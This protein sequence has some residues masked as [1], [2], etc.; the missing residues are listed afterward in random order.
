MIIIRIKKIVL[1]LLIIL[2][3]LVLLAIV[4][5]TLLDQSGFGWGTITFNNA[6]ALDVPISDVAKSGKNDYGI[7]TYRD[8]KNNLNISSW[9]SLEQQTIPGARGEINKLTNQKGS[10]SP[11]IEKG[12][13]VYYNNKT[14]LYYVQT[15]ND[16]THDNILISAP[17]KNL[18]LKVYGT[19]RYG[20]G[21]ASKLI[22][23]MS[24]LVESND[25]NTTNATNATNSSVSVDSTAS[26]GYYDESY[27]DESS[28]NEDY[29]Y[30]EGYYEDESYYGEYYDSEY[31]GEDYSYYEQY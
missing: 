24:N 15:A 12:V 14:G 6:T 2:V 19:I 28:Y 18:V 25:T 13:P 9:N 22:V 1:Y 27:Y 17:D 29:S 7:Y 31:Y 21:N 11:V 5:T 20:Y 26:Q 30:D 4:S 16:T 10:E 3:A 8:S 23:N